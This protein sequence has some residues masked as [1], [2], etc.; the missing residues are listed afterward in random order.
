MRRVKK[1]PWL[2]HHHASGF[3]L[4]DAGTHAGR[5]RVTLGC[6]PAPLVCLWL[7][8]QG[9]QIR[10]ERRKWQA[11][12]S[13][14][15]M[16]PYAQAGLTPASSA[17]WADLWPQTGLPSPLAVPLHGQTKGSYFLVYKVSQEPNVMKLQA[18]NRN[19]KKSRGSTSIFS[20]KLLLFHVPRDPP[21]TCCGDRLRGRSEF[22]FFLCCLYMLRLFVFEVCNSPLP[23]LGLCP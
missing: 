7:S 10:V 19:T 6:C 1:S 22:R 13:P 3:F 17:T 11:A 8:C 18:P 5:Q 20:P 14:R 9:L 21:P 15:Q 2:S 12:S 23:F 4:L 16:G